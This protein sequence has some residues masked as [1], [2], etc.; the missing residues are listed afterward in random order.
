M[1]HV[2]HAGRVQ[3]RSLLLGGVEIVD[4]VEMGLISALSLQREMSDEES[5]SQ[6]LQEVYRKRPYLPVACA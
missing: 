2:S 3:V 1:R 4:A 6:M 5:I